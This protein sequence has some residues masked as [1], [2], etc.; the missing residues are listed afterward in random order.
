MN[1]ESDSILS[2]L[3]N[4]LYPIIS[5]W[6]VIGNCLTLFVYAKFKRLQKERNVSV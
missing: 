1:S 3:V 2:K 4:Y 6:I 5:V